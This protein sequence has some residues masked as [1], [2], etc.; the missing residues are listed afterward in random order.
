MISVP[1]VQ[2]DGVVIAG[3]CAED[4]VV[5]ATLVMN[6][7][8]QRPDEIQVLCAAGANSPFGGHQ[9]TLVS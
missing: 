5:D 6:R 9:A 4:E 2:T 7:H 1:F 3:E 8:P